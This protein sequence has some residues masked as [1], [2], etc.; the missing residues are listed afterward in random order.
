M[1]AGSGYPDTTECVV[2]ETKPECLSFSIDN[3]PRS[4]IVFI[5]SLEIT[6]LIIL[7]NV[8][9]VVFGRWWQTVMWRPER[10]WQVRP[11]Q[12]SQLTLHNPAYE[13]ATGHTSST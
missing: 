4:D 7:C 2:R 5:V 12:P 6:Q 9:V 13:S 11:G 1:V 3:I 8:S 10:L